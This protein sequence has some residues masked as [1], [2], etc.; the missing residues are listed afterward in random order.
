M[1]KSGVQVI[2]KSLQLSSTKRPWRKGAAQENP[3]FLKEG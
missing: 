1:K 3:K 2:P